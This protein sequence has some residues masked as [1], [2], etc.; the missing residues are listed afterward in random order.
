MEK[1]VW[2]IVRLVTLL[3]SLLAIAA[4]GCQDPEPYHIPDPLQDP[5]V[6]SPV[7]QPVPNRCTLTPEDVQ[8]S[9]GVFECSGGT[10]TPLT[11]DGVRCLRC[12]GNFS[13]AGVPAV[14]C[15]VWQGTSIEGLCVNSCKQCGST[16]DNY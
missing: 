3:L 4:A 15:F 13:A 1:N 5:W 7:D 8:T 11:K 16:Q 6:G 9:I 10:D 14:G 2:K 12:Y